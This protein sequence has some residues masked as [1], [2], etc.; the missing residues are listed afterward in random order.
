MKN[1]KIA[2]S[3]P[4]RAIIIPMEYDEE[5]DIITVNEL[6]V[7]PVPEKDTDISTDLAFFIT[8]KILKSL[9]E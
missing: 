6:Q 4:D 8:Q 3:T 5:K 1:L 2:I 7:E 9:N